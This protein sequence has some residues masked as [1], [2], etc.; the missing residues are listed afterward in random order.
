MKRFFRKELLQEEMNLAVT[1]RREEFF[2]VA[3]RGKGF[4]GVT[5]RKEDVLRVTSR[6]KDVLRVTSR[7]DDFFGSYFNKRRVLE[8]VSAMI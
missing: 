5:S 4:L 1:S 8:L 2:R 7:K 3:S 6:K